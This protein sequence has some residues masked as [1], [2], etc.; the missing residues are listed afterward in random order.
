MESENTRFNADVFID[1][2]NIKGAPVLQMLDEAMQF[3]AAQP[4]EYLKTDSI[5][6]RYS[7]Y[8]P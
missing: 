3:S 6:R 2:M 4:V 8:V 1:F 5:W 7:S